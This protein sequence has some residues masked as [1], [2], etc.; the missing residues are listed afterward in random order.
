MRPI[1][2]LHSLT[3]SAALAGAQASGRG[4]Y[5]RTPDFSA[6]AARSTRPRT[7]RGTTF[8]F[9]H[10][11]VSKAQDMSDTNRSQTPSA[12][13][14]GYIERPSATEEIDEDIEREI[15]DSSEPGPE[16]ELLAPGYTYPKRVVD[17]GRASF[18]TL[19]RTKAERKDFWNIV[20]A[21]EG[22]RS[23]V[24]SRIIAELPHE[25]DRKGRC[26]IARDFCALLEER[27][28][29]YWATVHAPGAKNDSR[30]YH[31]HVTYFDRPS[32]ISEAGVWS[33]AHTEIRRKKNRTRRRVRPDVSPKHPDTRRR[34]WPREIRRSY[35]DIAN[36]HLALSGSE[37]RFDPRSYRDAGL[38]K[39]PTEHLGTKVAALESFGLDTEAGKR[40][41]RR[42]IRWRVTQAEEPWRMRMQMI[43]RGDIDLSA[44]PDEEKESLFDLANKGARC[45]RQSASM[46]IVSELLLTRARRRKKFLGKEVS[47]L[48]EKDD[49]ADFSERTTRVVALSSEDDIL[50][51]A[52]PALQETSRKTW[53]QG[54]RLSVQ[55]GKFLAAF[56]SRVA[57]RDPDRFFSPTLESERDD[58]AESLPDSDGFD[59]DD[60]DRIEDVFSDLGAVSRPAMKG[61]SSRRETRD[62][63]ARIE[64]VI[65]SISRSE[66]STE[67]PMTRAEARDAFPEAWPVERTHARADVEELDARLAALDNRTLRQTAVATR[68]AADLCGGADPQADFT[69]GWSVLR[70]EAERRGLDL[71]TGRHDPDRARDA[72][73]ARLHQDQD[74]VPLSVVR[75]NIARQRV[76]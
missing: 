41:A 34:D 66:S 7:D 73:R 58:F 32:G 52:L 33:H 67:Q 43:E 35:A 51:D 39:E 47:R 1:D 71:D 15:M 38:L 46:T 68:D 11:V 36:Y 60:L 12:A 25:L 30:N 42:E 59:S 23:R 69:R 9:A 61:R 31:L 49:M 24:Q 29:P 65:A 74:A 20:E 19:G 18:G 44:M 27:N 40:N 22:A 62:V 50:E 10:K 37:R 55:S 8:H 57:T 72:E 63:P 2:M 64:D 6:P 14:Q 5:A 28:L 13:H 17:R 26:A 16:E 21:S 53:A 4:R 3:D 70:F 75:K 48:V 56:D 76:R 45:A 54:R